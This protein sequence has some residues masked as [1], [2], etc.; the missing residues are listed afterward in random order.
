MASL[1]LGSANAAITITMT[2]NG[3][4]GITVTGSGTGIVSAA[5]AEDDWDFKD[6]NSNFLIGGDT[7]WDDDKDDGVSGTLTKTPLVGQT[8]VA[9]VF[10]M[11]P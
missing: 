1:M 2:D 4:G 9:N 8:V 10:Q 3:S 11:E 5:R 7:A 6:F